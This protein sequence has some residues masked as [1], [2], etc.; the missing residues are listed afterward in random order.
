MTIYRL[1]NST[2]VL[3]CLLNLVEY[4]LNVFRQMGLHMFLHH[5]LS[6]LHV[7]GVSL[8]RVKRNSNSHFRNLELGSHSPQIALHAVMT[9]DGAMHCRPIGVRC[10]F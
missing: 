2:D 4:H 6:H 8:K 3:S 9:S 5:R 7:T 1:V 10:A